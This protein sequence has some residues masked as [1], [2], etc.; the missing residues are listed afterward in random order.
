MI[1]GI[2][3]G[4]T[5]SRAFIF[6]EQGKVVTSSYSEIEQ[7]FHKPGL[8]EHDAAESWETVK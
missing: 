7:F 8:V 4:T 5:G 6:D 2:D 3:Q 1:L